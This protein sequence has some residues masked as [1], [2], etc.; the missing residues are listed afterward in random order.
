MI[1]IDS[2]GPH[3][4]TLCRLSLSH[5]DTHSAEPPTLPLGGEPPLSWVGAGEGAE[6]PVFPFSPAA[7]AGHPIPL[8]SLPVATQSCSPVVPGHRQSPQLQ[9]SSQRN[10][11]SSSE[12]PPHPS[13][14]TS[15]KETRGPGRLLVQPPI[16]CSVTTCSLIQQT[17]RVPSVD[18][19]EC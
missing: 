6:T 15:Q 17:A 4:Q 8:N 1:C 7:R 3:T 16:T 19:A 13:R 11:L 2:G 14:Q 10:Q 5:P 9:G 18:Q 12:P